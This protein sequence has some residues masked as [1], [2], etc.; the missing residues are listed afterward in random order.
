M[1]EAQRSASQFAGQIAARLDRLPCS[2]SLWRI[3]FLVSIGGALEFYDLFLSAYIA[4]GLVASGQFTSNAASLFSV[5]GVGFFVFCTFAGMWVGSV[6]FGSIADRMGRRV[7]FIY[8][9]IWYSSSTAIMGMQT[10]A[11][12]VDLWRF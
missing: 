12:G 10:S 8:S 1:M 2:R 6:C 5:N 4:P 3:V 7:I 11:Q 9:L